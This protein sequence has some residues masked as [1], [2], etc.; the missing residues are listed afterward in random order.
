MTSPLL[1]AV[2]G[3][4]IAHSKSPAMHG[5]AYRALGLPHRYEAIRARP[6]ELAAVVARVRAG[7]LAGINV[8][9]PHKARV[10]DLVD[11]HAPS[12]ALAGA[13]NTIVRERDGALVAH[14]TDAPAL[15]GEV[16]RLAARP[17]GG[18]S[19][20]VLG[21]GGA[22]RGAVAALLSLGV[23]TI[24]VRGRSLAV[25]AAAG[26]FADALA[27]L[28]ERAGAVARFEVGPLAADSADGRFDVVLQAT[29]AGMTGVEGGEALASAVELSRLSGSVVIDLVYAPRETAFLRAARACGLAAENGIGMLVGQG[30]LAFELWLGTAAPRAAMRAALDP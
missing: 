25:P 29:S 5:A 20:L 26:T 19:A 1:F 21:T 3:D 2:V 9:V 30:A 28:A 27:R 4:P 22:A 23:T 14:N 18:A 6:D 13:A 15:A 10:L 11:A 7:D 17:L 16:A 24:A 12:A 8:T